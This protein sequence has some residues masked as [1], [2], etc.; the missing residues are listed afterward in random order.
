MSR[1]PEGRPPILQ[2]IDTA[3]PGGAE[4]VFRQLVCGPMA[5][6]LSLIP[7][8]PR[9]G[10]LAKGLRQGGASP[11]IIPC[12]GSFQVSYL[13][14]LMAIVRRE[15]VKLIHAH[16]IGSATYAA[17]L[18]LLTGVPVIATF[19]GPADFRTIGRLPVLK[20]WLL[21]HQLSR[22]VAVSESTREA[23]LDF[24]LKDS[25][26]V[27]I[28][29]GVDTEQFMP[30]SSA[31]L[32]KDLGIHE[33]AFLYGAVGNIRK[34]KAYDI[35]LEAAAIVKR[36]LPSAEFVVIGE[37]SE[38]QMAPLKA[39]R[40]A[41][42]LEGCFHFA[43]LRPATK[44][45]YQSFDVFVSSSS[46]EGLP[47]SMLE[48]MACGRGI[49]ATASGGAQQVLGQGEYGYVVP[50]N[51]PDRLADGMLALAGQLELRGRLGALARE[52]V[53]REYSLAATI[54][55]NLDLYMQVMNE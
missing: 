4:T 21:R 53:E 10:W 39:L 49:V 16:L 8:I 31:T 44:E 14:Q 35:L 7:V 26:I 6:Q 33:R 51:E 20:R 42:N 43:G 18:K 54:Q 47:L 15:R 52:R 22:V 37:G 29:N 23:V 1:S 24:G 2:L 46:S 5:Q 50:I 41:L 32:R 28:N 45:I 55:S 27:V 9:D 30:G 19:H 48:A 36:K 40:N 34:P 17:L 3:G 38:A 11:R 25:D 12:R 13:M